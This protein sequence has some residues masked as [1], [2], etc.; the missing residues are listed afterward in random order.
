MIASRRLALVAVRLMV[1]L[2]AGT[3]LTINSSPVGFAAE[4]VDY[5]RDVKPLLKNKCYACHGAF[6]QQGG[7][8]LDTAEAL[9]QGGD[10]GSPITAG[11]PD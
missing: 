3:F 2:L 11:K 7:L 10:S 6:K 8:R 9:H 1:T 4:T 5:A